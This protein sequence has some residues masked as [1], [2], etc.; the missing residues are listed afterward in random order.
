MRLKKGSASQEPLLLVAAI[1]LIV[2][3]LAVGIRIIQKGEKGLLGGTFED[4]FK[5]FKLGGI[6]SECP[7]IKRDQQVT[8]EQ[9][10]ELIEDAKN[11][12]GQYSDNVEGTNWLNDVNICIIDTKIDSIS[13]KDIGNKIDSK[14]QITGEQSRCYV[15]FETGILSTL[16]GILYDVA[17]FCPSEDWYTGSPKNFA[18]ENAI[19]MR[20]ENRGIGGTYDIYY[21]WG[22]KYFC[23]QEEIFLSQKEHG[24]SPN[25][26]KYSMTG[27]TYDICTKNGYEFP[28]KKEYGLIS[29]IDWK[30]TI[31]DT[32]NKCIAS[33]VLENGWHTCV[34]VFNNPDEPQDLEQ[35]TFVAWETIKV[36]DIKNINFGKWDE[37]WTKIEDASSLGQDDWFILVKP[38]SSQKHITDLEITTKVIEVQESGG[39]NVVPVKGDAAGITDPD[40]ILF[41]YGKTY[42]VEVYK[43]YDPTKRCLTLNCDDT[44]TVI[45]EIS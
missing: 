43:K 6:T 30:T 29:G 34:F 13:S 5:G 19:V 7:Y 25:N 39:I 27:K 38:S 11:Y 1:I 33:R 18:G 20:R 4:L 23:G 37:S 12:V 31:A 42:K 17:Y 14:L 24:A 15:H 44:I 41:S 21:L 28:E 3:L 2:I 36:K 10:L 16:A 35:V 9:F 40:T 22:L 26:Y 8:K 45:Y 32:I